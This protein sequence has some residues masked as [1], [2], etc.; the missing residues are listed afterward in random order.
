MKFTGNYFLSTSKIAYF[1]SNLPIQRRADLIQRHK[2][3]ITGRFRSVLVRNSSD[4]H[5]YGNNLHAAESP[6]HPSGKFPSIHNTLG[7]HRAPH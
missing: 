2:T 7:M 1:E 6:Q 3:K 5:S 4:N